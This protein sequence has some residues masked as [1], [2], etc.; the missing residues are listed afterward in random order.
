M[1]T[2]RLSFLSDLRDFPVVRNLRFWSASDRCILMEPFKRNLISK[3]CLK[4]YSNSIKS[5][6]EHSA[7]R[8]YFLLAF[9]GISALLVGCGGGGGGATG[10]GGVCPDQNLTINS[11][12]PLGQNG[13]L[14]LSVF[15]V[16]EPKSYTWEGPNGFVSHEKEPEIPNPPKG[17]QIYRLSVVT[18]GGC[19]YTATSSAIVVTGPWNPCGLDSNVIDISPVTTISFTDIQGRVNGSNYL[20]QASTSSLANADFEFNGNQPPAEGQYTVQTTTGA[21]QP[22]KVR[23]VVKVT[24]QEPFTANEGTVYVAVDGRVTLVSFCNV[25]FTSINTGALNTI[26]GAN[27]KWRPVQ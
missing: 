6:D 11:N 26:G 8:Q 3:Y 19:T 15:G 18:N 4:Y 9:I 14:K 1:P 22:G 17:N 5:F 12:A 16:S 27:L 24:T 7:M 21:V 10:G 20:I 2:S 13:V 25:K 23:V